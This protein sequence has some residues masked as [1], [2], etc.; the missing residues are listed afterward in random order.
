MTSR[1]P[2]SKDVARALVSN[3][4]RIA[5]IKANVKHIPVCSIMQVLAIPRLQPTPSVLHSSNGQQ[6]K[7]ATLRLV[8]SATL[9]QPGGSHTV[10]QPNRVCV[11]V[12]LCSSV[13]LAAA[14]MSAVLH[15]CLLQLT[16]TIC[17]HPNGS[18]CLSASIVGRCDHRRQRL[19]PHLHPRGTVERANTCTWLH[20]PCMQPSS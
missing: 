10:K 12:L 20:G 8:L 5:R 4:L 6:G 7:Q 2:G 3:A 13:S 11:L 9:Q 19:L 17:V 15:C 1:R 18:R 14:H 16:C